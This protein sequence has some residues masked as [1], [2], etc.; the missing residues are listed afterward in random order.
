V[1][2][3]ISAYTNNMDTFVRFVGSLRRT[4]Y[5]GKIILGVHKDISQEESDYLVS[6]D[7]TMYEVEFVKCAKNE[8]GVCARGIETLK[9]EWC[10][11]EMSRQWLRACKEDVGDGHAGRNFFSPIRSHCCP[12]PLRRLTICFS[13]K[14]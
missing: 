12:I 7:V 8:T 9:L 3:G 4:G 10:R 14:R 6:M 5:D 1:A 11:F 13:L 2:V